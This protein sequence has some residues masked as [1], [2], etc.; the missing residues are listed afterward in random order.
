MHALRV[1]VRVAVLAVLLLGLSL[2]SATPPTDLD[3]SARCEE[4]RD[5]GAPLALAPGAWTGA[6][7]DVAARGWVSWTAARP[8]AP[9]W[10]VAAKVR[11]RGPPPAVTIAPLRST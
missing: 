2:P 9:P 7:A 11:A 8:A 4:A 5:A 3:V 10:P 1:L 6:V